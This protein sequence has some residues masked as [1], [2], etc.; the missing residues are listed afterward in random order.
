MKKIL[1]IL[2]FIP[3]FTQAQTVYEVQGTSY[4]LKNKLLSWVGHMYKN[5]SKVIQF[6]TDNQIVIDGVSAVKGFMGG[7]DFT[8]TITIDFKDDRYRVSF[9]QV[10]VDTGML[11]M[12]NYEKSGNKKLKMKIEAALLELEESIYKNMT[13]ID[14]W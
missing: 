14:E 8:Y 13:A 1:I 10:E 7:T 4:E 2:L 6:E 9:D 12:M 3:L 11:G 5:P